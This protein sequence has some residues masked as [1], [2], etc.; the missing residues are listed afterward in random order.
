VSEGTEKQGVGGLIFFG[1]N[2]LILKQTGG[3]NTFCGVRPLKQ[4]TDG[5]LLPLSA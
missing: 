2:K 1:L 4:K 3:Q 5:Y